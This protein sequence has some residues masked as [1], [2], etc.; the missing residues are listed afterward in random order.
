MKKLITILSLA[1][2]AVRKKWLSWCCHDRECCEIINKIYADNQYVFVGAFASSINNPPGENNSGGL[3]DNFGD[4]N[5]DVSQEEYDSY[6]IG[7]RY[8]WE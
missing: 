5:I 1:S 7:D 8:C 4:V 2:F 6:E 3:G